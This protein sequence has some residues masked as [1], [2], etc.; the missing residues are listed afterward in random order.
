MLIIED[1]AQ[2]LFKLSTVQQLDVHFHIHLNKKMEKYIHSNP[3]P[4]ES[5]RSFEK[6]VSNK[7]LSSK[8]QLN[9]DKS[10]KEIISTF[11]FDRYEKNTNKKTNNAEIEELSHVFFRNLSAKIFHPV[12]YIV[13]SKGLNFSNISI[14]SEEFQRL[15]SNLKKNDADLAGMYFNIKKKYIVHISNQHCSI[16]FRPKD[17]PIALNTLIKEIPKMKEVIHYA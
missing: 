17:E 6:P 5:L 13:Y 8:L 15:F 1:A 11:R 4:F 12:V 9:Y 2:E 10:D 14:N 7:K 16:M 3:S